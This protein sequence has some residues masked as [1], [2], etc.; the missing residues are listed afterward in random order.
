MYGSRVIQC[1]YNVLDYYQ[2]CRT[3]ANRRT[4]VQVYRYA[5]NEVIEMG[6]Y[7]IEVKYGASPFCL[8]GGCGDRSDAVMMIINI[9]KNMKGKRT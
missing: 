2:A 7:V 9:N 1:Y 8:C 6:L 4:S 5:R 3:P